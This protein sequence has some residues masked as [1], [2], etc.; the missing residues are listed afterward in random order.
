MGF[1][2]TLTHL[3][4]FFIGFSLHVLTYCLVIKKFGYQ[5]LVFVSKK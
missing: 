3:R 1:K 2:L 4:K 5:V